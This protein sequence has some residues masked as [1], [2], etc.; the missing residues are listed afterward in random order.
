MVLPK[1]HDHILTELFVMKM[2]SIGFNVIE[3]E[4]IPSLTA[5]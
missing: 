2:S 3:L 4:K 1:W 5:L